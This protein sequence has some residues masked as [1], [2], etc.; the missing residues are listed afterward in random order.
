MLFLGDYVD[1]GIHGIEVLIILMALKINYPKQVIMLRGN[2]ESRSMTTYFTYRQECLDKYDV[3][4]YD[5]FME[6]FDNLPLMATVND[7]FL[8]VHGGISPDLHDIQDVNSKINRF[9]E[10]PNVGLFCDLLWSD[11][12]READDAKLNDWLRND[13]RDCSWIY[14]MRPVKNL[15]RKERLLTLV[16]AHE[17]QAQGYNVCL[18]EGDE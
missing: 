1:R 9:M 12:H 11:P 8:C 6:M 10:P 13:D 18:W 2:H 14:G 17:V 4:I 5:A 3:E 7:L 16:R 15:L